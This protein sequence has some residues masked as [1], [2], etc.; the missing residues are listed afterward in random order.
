M[1]NICGTYCFF[2]SIRR[3]T[4]VLMDKCGT[5]T[6]RQMADR[7]NLVRKIICDRLHVTGDE[8]WIYFENLKC[9]ISWV[10]PRTTINIDR[11]TETLWKEDNSVHFVGSE[12]CRVSLKL[13]NPGETVQNRKKWICSTI[14]PH[15]TQRKRSE[16]PFLHLAENT[17]S[18]R[19]THQT[20]PLP[21]TTCFHRCLTHF[22]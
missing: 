18:T 17:F 5:K 21:T 15:I 7:L 11:K 16:T 19:R 13:L 9:K 4:Q 20:W 3:K 8:T 22:P 10:W 6:Q 12:K 2:C 1:K 14:T